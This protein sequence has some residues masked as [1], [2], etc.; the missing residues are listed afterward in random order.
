VVQIEQKPF[1]PLFKSPCGTY[2][3][4]SIDPKRWSFKP[5]T[6]NATLRDVQQTFNFS[7]GTPLSFFQAGWFIDKEPELREELNQVGCS[8][9]QEFGKNIF[10]CRITVP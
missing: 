4:I 3:V 9:P 6:F 1:Q 2:S 10:L 8:A 7:P 5:D